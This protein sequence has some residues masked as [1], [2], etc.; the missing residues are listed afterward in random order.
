MK[1]GRV[2]FAKLRSH[3]KPLKEGSGRISFVF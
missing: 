1:A 3:G 2:A